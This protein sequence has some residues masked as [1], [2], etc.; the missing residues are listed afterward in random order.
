MYTGTGTGEYTGGDAEENGRL[1]SLFKEQDA[2]QPLPP[3]RKEA[4]KRPKINQGKQE[5]TNNNSKK[6]TVHPASGQSKGNSTE[7]AKK[8]QGNNYRPIRSLRHKDV[9]VSFDEWR[10]K[11]SQGEREL[12]QN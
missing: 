9:V 4:P 6:T 3:K 8:E 5:G 11:R 7:A 12:R 10:K 1:Q 2:P